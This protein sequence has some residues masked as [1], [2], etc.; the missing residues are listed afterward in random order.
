M[1]QP[2][3]YSLN[4]PSPLQAFGQAFNV[5]A[6]GQKARYA[7]ED[8]AAAIAKKASDDA[9]I[10]AM[11]AIPVQDRTQDQYLRLG[12]INP[13][14]AELAQQQFDSLSE[15]Q[16]Q[17]SFLD[18]TQIHT[19]LRGSLLGETDFEMVDQIFARRLDATKGNPAL[20]KM[21]SDARKIARTDPEAAEAMVGARIATL[22]GGKEYF[23]AMKTRGEEARAVALDPQ[24]RAEQK[25]KVE[26]LQDEIKFNKFEGFQLMAEAG[27]DINSLVAEDAQIRGPLEQMA[28]RQ[29]QLQL[30]EKDKNTAAAEKL[31]LEIANL[32][33]TA[34][35]KAQTKIN[36][37]NN[38]LSGSDDLITFIN[39]ILK[40]G[41]SPTDPDS[42]MYQV[43]GTIAGAV[44]SLDQEN[45]N[46]EK[47]IETLKSKIYLDKVALMRGTGPLS[48]RE[49]AKLETAMRSLELRQGPKQAFDNLIE[50]QELAVANQGLIKK[51]YGDIPTLERQ[52]AGESTRP[53]QTETVVTDTVLQVD[54]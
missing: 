22:P 42:A 23:D 1:A 49:G 50:I 38:A 17:N 46:F 11:F 53:Q 48:D 33:N 52:A 44:P 6:A 15:Q 29:K 24:K 28:K 10:E 27:V 13:Q 19:A 36:D 30:A 43:F 37:V 20:N 2:Y 39:K 21:W 25:L 3:D 14:I 32:K 8:R 35:E 51:K 47:M 7:R 26:R 4:I 41:G 18:A 45:V 31:Q 5:G 34:Q 16:Q 54:F 9:F 12:M 40:A